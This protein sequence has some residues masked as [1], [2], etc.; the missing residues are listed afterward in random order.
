MTK[1]DMSKASYGYG[2]GYDYQYSYSYGATPEQ[3]AASNDA[4]AVR[5]H[6]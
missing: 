4:E 5:R 6:A 2:Y 1:F 3:A